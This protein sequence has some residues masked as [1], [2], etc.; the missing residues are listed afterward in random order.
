MVELPLNPPSTLL[1]LCLGQGSA[2]SS[3][4]K[5]PGFCRIPIP[6][7]IEAARID[8]GFSPSVWGSISHW[9]SS[10]VLISP[11]LYLSFLR[12]CL[13]CGLQASASDVKTT[14]LQRPLASSQDYVRSYLCNKSYI[15]HL[16][17]LVDLFPWLTPDPWLTG[18]LPFPGSTAI[19]FSLPLCCRKCQMVA[20][21][22]GPASP[23]TTTRLASSSDNL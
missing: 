9:G 18:A 19:G 12:S 23:H 8:T 3:T 1:L 20:N 16:C 22:L 2:F 21:S 6:L 11:T 10:L 4:P 17:L 15:S 13:S 7:N 14:A 5:D